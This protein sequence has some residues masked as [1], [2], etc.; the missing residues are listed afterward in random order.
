MPRAAIVWIARIVKKFFY[1]FL[2]ISAILLGGV[3]LIVPGW[4]ILADRPI[5]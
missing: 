3:F 4:W 2:D 1:T 5:A